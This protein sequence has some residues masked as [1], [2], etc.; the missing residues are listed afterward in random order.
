MKRNEYWE[1]KRLLRIREDLILECERLYRE[2]CE[3]R[4]KK[5]ILIDELVNYKK[6]KQ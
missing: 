1:K 5:N 4:A 3:L 2:N 6:D